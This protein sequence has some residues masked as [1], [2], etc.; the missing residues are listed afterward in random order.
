MLYRFV[1]NKSVAA[2]TFPMKLAKK[3]DKRKML[4]EIK[5]KDISLELSQ[6]ET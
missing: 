6:L 3:K 1:N 4:E 5:F 2:F